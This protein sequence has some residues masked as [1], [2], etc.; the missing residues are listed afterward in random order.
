MRKLDTRGDTPSMDTDDSLK[1]ELIEHPFQFREFSNEPELT[2]QIVEAINRMGGAGESAEEEYRECLSPLIR[3]V[4]RVV[5]IIQAEYF[6]MPEEAYLD[7]WALVMLATELVDRRCVDFFKAVLDSEIPE[8]KSKYPHSF[9]TVGEEIMIRTTVIEGLERLAKDDNNEAME[10]LFKNIQHEAFS[11]RRATTQAL[12]EVGGEE[13]RD[14]L[15]NELPERHQPL[16]KIRRTDVR[17]AEQAKGGLF[18][19]NRDDDTTPI[20]NDRGSTK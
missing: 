6:D 14:R 13:M 1:T 17:E 4:K 2:A 5:Q 3:Q 9:T 10:L 15:A 11:I 7:R 8:E 16:L 18:L 20:P 19:K 12:I